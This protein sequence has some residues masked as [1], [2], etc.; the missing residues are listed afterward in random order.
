[1]VTTH[2]PAFIDISKDNTTII[3]VYKDESGDIQGT[4]VCRPSKVNLT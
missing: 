1:M 3:R 4:T 2:A